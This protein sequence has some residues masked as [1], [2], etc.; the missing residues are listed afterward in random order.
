MAEGIGIDTTKF[1]LK[2]MRKYYK[3]TDDL[4]EIADYLRTSLPESAGS[5]SRLAVG[6]FLAQKANKLSEELGETAATVA[7]TL[8]VIVAIVALTTYFV[9]RT[10]HNTGV[11]WTYAIT[12]G[13]LMTAFFVISPLI[14]YV[15]L[16]DRTIIAAS[17]AGETISYGTALL[18][19]VTV[20]K[21]LSDGAKALGVIGL[22]VAISIAVGFFIA[23]WANGSA[24]PGSVA[25]NEG[26]A[27]TIASVVVAVVLFVIGLFVLGGILVGILA[28][29]D[30]ILTAV[31]VKWTIT[32]T[33]TKAI[34]SVIYQ[35]NVYTDQ[36]QQTGALENSLTDPA[37]GLTAGNQISFTLP[38]TTT[39]TQSQDVIALT[40][41]PLQENS[42]V[43]N[44][45]A[46]PESL[47]T[48]LNAGIDWILMPPDQA[49]YTAYPTT[50]I[51]LSPGINSQVP[52]Q[53]NAGWALTAQ[54]CWT[55][56]CS[57]K[58]LSGSSSTAINDGLIFDIFPETLDEFVDI[59]TAGWAK[60]QLTAIDS[61]G[62]GL[63]AQ[64]KGG[65]DPDDTQWDTDGDGLSD[66]YELTIRSRRPDEGGLNLDPR[67]PD[68]DDDFVG[69]YTE[70]FYGTN[71]DNG[72][73]DDDGI[74]DIDELPYIIDVNGELSVAGWALP[75]AP[76]KTT[77]VWSNPL[78][79]DSDGDGLSDLFERTQVTCPTCTPWVDPSNPA[80]FNPNVWNIS[81]VALSI[82]DRSTDGFVLPGA[83]VVY[84]STTVNN[85]SGG[86]LLSGKLSVNAPSIFTADNTEAQ[87]NVT[88]GASE[89]LV[90]T[91]RVNATSSTSGVVASTMELTDYEATV[92]SWDDPSSQSVNT[93]NQVQDVVTV[94]PPGWG[95]AI[96]LVTHEVAENGIHSIVAHLAGATGE[97]RERQLLFT[98]PAGTTLTAP[99][100]A[101]LDDSTCLVAW[102][103]HSGT[104]GFVWHTLMQ[105]AL[106]ANP[107][108]SEVWSGS[109]SEMPTPAAA[110]HGSTFM[111]VWATNTDPTRSF[112]ALPIAGNVAASSAIP[113]ATD[114]AVTIHT[115]TSDDLSS[116]EVEWNGLSYT[117]FWTEDE[118]I[119]RAQLDPV[120]GV[121]QPPAA[122]QPGRGWLTPATF[123]GPPTVVF[124]PLSRQVL[125]LYQG[126]DAQL[127]AGRLND[128]GSFA[129]LSL[130]SSTIYDQI[131]ARTALCADPK[132]SG[133]IAAWSPPSSAEILYQAVGPDGTLRGPQQTLTG[134]TAT[135]IA[136]SCD[137]VRPLLDLE[138][139]EEAGATTFVDS[140]GY[141]HDAACTVCP[142]S[143]VTGQL[144]NGVSFNQ[145]VQYDL[146]TSFAQPTSGFTTEVWLRNPLYA[147]YSRQESLQGMYF[148][149]DMI[150]AAVT[151]TDNSYNEICS[152][153][154][155]TRSDWHHFV[156]VGNAD[157]HQIYVDG[158]L[159]AA[160]NTLQYA[161]C[162]SGN[163]T[164]FSIGA[165]PKRLV[166]DYDGEMD[167]LSFYD[168]ALSAT[169][170]ASNFKAASAIYDL[171]DVAGSIVIQDASGNSRTATCT[172]DTCPTLGV[173]GIAYTAA[174]FDGDDFY[175][176]AG[177]LANGAFTIS[178]WAKR[179]AIGAD[180]VIVA[181]GLDIGGAFGVQNNLD[182][183]FRADDR[184]T[185][186]GLTPDTYQPDI[187][188]TADTYSDTEWNHWA[189]TYDAATKLRTIYRNGV[190]VAQATANSDYFYSANITTSIGKRLGDPWYFDG[191]IDEVGDLGQ[192]PQR[193]RDCRTVQQGQAEDHSDGARSRFRPQTEQAHWRKRRP[194]CVR[195]PRTWGP[196]RRR[197]PAPSPSTPTRRRS[198]GVQRRVR[199]KTLTSATPARWSWPARPRIRH[200]TSVRST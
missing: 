139:D 15:K 62:D 181:Q 116:P 179:N 85:L 73:S 128:D 113:A 90:T 10:V 86:Q 149:N 60:G 56:F 27:L 119:L 140:S 161:A 79:G 141:G 138:F 47:S 65:L 193:R 98:A 110:G 106:P 26:L 43:Y 72:D 122:I 16:L 37:A 133:W 83:T 147:V 103:G 195:R 173:P 45:T 81:P 192:S 31:G 187:L 176:H 58:P 41:P 118:S 35:Y 108:I 48:S 153:S 50:Q 84:T 171:D 150:C 101:C 148:F 54:S 189:C 64:S 4:A 151:Q 157:N 175:E 99:S 42:L 177:S 105:G 34:A 29:I 188:N 95:Q 115:T 136:L 51:G 53:L 33:I 125:L 132:N 143:G 155:I 32:G 130:D 97:I 184:F 9:S 6:E 199:S 55:I 159:V 61:D 89:S 74:P 104:N 190:P 166:F 11:S 198:V 57:E 1:T 59:S 182:F 80:V 77:L 194:S 22:L 69:D 134:N 39:L 44:L 63:L 160:S 76:G 154:P 19:T 20:M 78:L 172:G 112:L 2:V 180:A 124:D 17:E 163:C 94:S 75:Y 14:S 131:G 170:I 52:L 158:E 129:P 5:A 200:R 168:R 49:M 186:S 38:I 70:L 100:V 196:L 137:S 123:D 165:F 127:Y 135:G 66:G 167:G 24:K 71:P 191:V 3:Y 152:E 8:V 36:N 164:D 142:E 144:G 96:L 126:T 121:A 91:L 88:S 111:I 30:L 93:D 109:S 114:A 117:A 178:A 18:R 169:E 21:T 102:A 120:T 28:V 197:P 162:S 145:A 174:Q 82:N 13:V 185:C 146:A 107:A 7:V 183:G 23:A 156:H 46:Q 25:F 92:W 12:A 67:H 40:V 87:V 68:G